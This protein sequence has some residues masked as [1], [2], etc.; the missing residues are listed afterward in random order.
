MFKHYTKQLPSMF[1]LYLTS[2][3][4]THKYNTR[5]A[6]DYVIIKTKRVSSDRAVQNCGPIF[7]NSLSNDIKGCNNTKQ[8]RNHLKSSLLSS[9]DD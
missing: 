1:S 5:N 2:H 6:Q 8:F 4:Q 9:Y 7:W 3:D